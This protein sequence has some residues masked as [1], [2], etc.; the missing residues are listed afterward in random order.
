MGDSQKVEPIGQAKPLRQR[1]R[2]KGRAVDPQALADVREL[3][4]RRPARTATLLIEHLHQIQDRLRPHIA[5]GCSWRSRA[6]SGSRP[7]RSTRWRRST[8]TSTW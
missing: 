2:P 1:G 4:W 3:L 8:I 5:G 6:S 7:R